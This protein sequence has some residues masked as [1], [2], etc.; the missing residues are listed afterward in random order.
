MMGRTRPE[1]FP[2]FSAKQRI[3]E[4]NKIKQKTKNTQGSE[5]KDLIV[6]IITWS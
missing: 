3:Y 6:R 4:E 1:G 2:L 5:M